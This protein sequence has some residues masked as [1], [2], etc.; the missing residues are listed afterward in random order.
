MGL[1]I[2]TEKGQKS[3]ADE[4]AAHT[5]IKNLW[6]VDIIETPKNS[7]AKCDGFLVKD[8]VITALF[9]TKCRYDMDY[10]KLLERGTWLVTYEKIA[11]CRKLSQSLGVPFFGFLYLLPRSSDEQLLLY[12]EITDGKGEYQFKFQIDKEETQKTING[13]RIV[14]ENAYLPVEY[15]KIVVPLN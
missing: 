3:L 1:D 8:N 2:N 5:I 4:H 6:K 10:Q 15:S 14:R 9:E 12:W 13:S 7:P 11:A